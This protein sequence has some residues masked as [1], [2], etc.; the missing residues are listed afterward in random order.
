M[1]EAKFVD[2]QLVYAVKDCELGAF[3]KG[4]YGKVVGIRESLTNTYVVR[5]FSKTE[6]V[7]AYE[8]ELGAATSWEM[9]E[10]ANEAAVK[11]F[12]DEIPEEP[13]ESICEVT[14]YVKIKGWPAEYTHKEL[15]EI[16]N[17]IGA[18]I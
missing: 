3:K 17:T 11:F 15:K 13:K 6:T 2:Q 16:Y 9:I 4:D 18:I 8:H 1:S 7:D 5:F 10:K 14:F 12:Q